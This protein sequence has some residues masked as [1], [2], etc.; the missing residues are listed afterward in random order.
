MQLHPTRNTFQVALAGAAMVAVGVA[1]KVSAAVAFGGAMLLAITLGRALALATVTRIRA[2]GFEMVWSMT[3]RVTRVDRGGEVVIEAE[4]RNRGFDDARGVSLRP[5]ASS[6]LD[7]T[8]DPPVLDLPAASKV[9]F[10]VK[11]RAKRVGRWGMHGIA[12][13]VRG[14]PLGGEGLYEVPLM[15]ANPHG[16]EVVP[17]PLLAMLETAKGGRA[18]AAAPAGRSAPLT[19]DGEQLKELREHVPGDPFKRIAWR[20]S[21]RRGTLLVREMERE[22]RD[23]VW[24][25]IDASVELWAGEEGRAPLDIAVDEVGGVAARHL[26]RGDKVGLV[27]FASR[28]RTWLAADSGPQQATRIV[29]A[30]ASTA[31]AVDADRSEEGESELAARVAEHLRPLDPRG[32]ADVPRNNLDSLATR[33]EALRV[34]APFAPRLPHAPTPRE[35]RLRHYLAAFGIEVPPRVDGE[36]EKAELQLGAALEKIALEKKKKPSIVHVWAPPPSPDGDA[37]ARGLRKLRARHVDVRWT[38]PSFEPALEGEP[39]ALAPVEEVVRQAVKMRVRA[40][41][42][43]AERALRSLGARAR[44]VERRRALASADPP[45]EAEAKGGP[46]A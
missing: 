3:R 8:I 9:R 6:M 30:L 43:R 36:R 11:V 37:V 17:K 13:E 2:S 27:V 38:M 26:A 39:G 25:V 41:Q 21:A 4:L 33:A 16:I 15:F 42:A 24:L 14:T 10:D 40:S 28:V 1:A 46:Q 18:R 44:A 29:A 20:A 19:G 12:L 23:I 5:V 31:S 34:R 32:L 7:V 45:P 22:E 35:Q